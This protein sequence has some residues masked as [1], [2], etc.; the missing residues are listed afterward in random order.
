M[1]I[2]LL[3]DWFLP[4]LGGLELQLRD[5][6]A[7]LAARG[8]QVDVVTTTPVD[9]LVQGALQTAAVAA[10]EGVGVHR[11]GLPLVPGLRVTFS[12]RAGVAVRHLL[13]GLDPDVLH[14]HASIGS[15]AALSGVWAGHTLRLPT[16]LT[17]HSVLG[18]HRHLL[19]AFDLAFGWT[20]WPQVL[21]AVSHPVAREIGWVA[22]DRVV[23]VLPNGVD[24]AAWLVDP[25]PGPEGEFRLVSVLRLQSRKRGVALLRVAAAAAERL[26]GER[27][28]RLTVIGDGPQRPR[29][30]R[31]AR[32]LGIADRVEFTGYLPRPAI[33][34]Q[35]TRAD[36]FVLVSVLESFGIAALEAR[37]AGLPVVARGDSGMGELLVQGKEA[38]LAASD[39][40][41]VEHLVR[42]AIDGRL[43]A[44][45]ARHNRSTPPEV[46]W[47]RTV[48]RHLE[49]Y[50]IARSGRTSE[51]FAAA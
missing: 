16:V 12:P 19:R 42:L 49:V 25:L 51:A 10:P 48:A 35:F 9:P 29:L 38:L 21:S 30:E 27:R 15:T 11:L 17:F 37:A 26:P 50:E 7:E 23:E 43:R 32:R 41:V 36:A 34:D 18:P 40:G 20:R 5:L 47:V 46:S 4:R 39:A 2:V 24:R 31:E 44:R 6:A 14:V 13:Q 1:K 33:R 22:A 3:S 28:M 8:N 45:I